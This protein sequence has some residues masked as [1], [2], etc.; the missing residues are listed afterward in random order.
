MAEEEAP[1][2]GKTV[3]FAGALGL[4]ARR[5][6]GRAV[7]AHGGQLRRGLTR[8][9]DILVVGQGATGP[10][11]LGQL[12]L[13]L[14]QA[15]RFGAAC[16]GEAAFLR[17]VRLAPPPPDEPRPHLLEEL[18]KQTGVDPATLR[19]LGLFDLVMPVE[20]RYRFRDLVTAREVARLLREGSTLADILSSATLM[21][22]RGGDLAGMRLVRLAAG[23]LGVRVGEGLADLD[24]QMQLPIAETGPDLDALFE[25]AEA[26]EAAGDLAQAERLYA[27]CAAASPDDPT[28]QFNLAN[29]LRGRRQGPE[30]ELRYRRAV[31]LDPR[32]AEAWYN[33]AHVMSERGRADLAE[34]Y[35]GQAVEA[36]PAFGD[37]LYNL[38]QLRFERDDFAGAMAA[39][40]L[41]LS[42]D[43]D[44]AWA[45]KARA[46]LALCRQHLKAS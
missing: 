5:E 12:E 8:R 17:L 45:R 20:G 41:Y 7:A 19:L 10:A 37:A 22:S 13:K 3:V 14:A 18:Q 39:W 16:I 30:A 38:A 4:V 32:F 25:A 1:L 11:A 23:G 9:T 42:Q 43:R 24:G 21:Q 36:D 6:A 35:L 46:G 44:S 29:V 28:V 26:A 2:A 40:Q 33:L 27:A 15:D 34:R 31:A